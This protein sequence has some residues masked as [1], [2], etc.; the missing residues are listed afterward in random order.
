M[1]NMLNSVKTFYKSNPWKG[2]FILLFITI[3]LI[4]SVI[5]ISLPQTIIY[6]AT[7]WLNKQGIDS[8]IEA[9]NI[10]ILDGTVS[11]INAKGSK[12]NQPLFNIGLVDIH[13]RWAPLSKKTVE[14]TK[15]V[16]DQLNVNIEQYTDGIVIGG[17]YIPLNPS[18]NDSNTKSDEITNSDSE[19][20]TTWAASL[21]EVIFT[22]LNV[23]YLQHTSS[24]S[25]T[26]DKTKYIDYCALLDEMN[27]SGTINYATDAALIESSNLPLSSS[28]DFL[29]RGLTIIDNKLKRNL[30]TSSSNTISNVVFTGLNNININEINMSGLSA[31]Q[32]DDKQ[33]NDTV[34]FQQ[35]TISDISLTNLNSLD[36][37]TVAVSQP[38]LYLIK[39]D[40]KNWEYQP[41]LPDSSNDNSVAKGSKDKQSKTDPTPIKLTIKNIKIDDTDF[42]Y[43]ENSI[44]LYYCFTL[45][46]FTWDGS[47]KYVNAFSSTEDFNL[48]ARGALSLTHPVIINH[49]L[50]RTLLDLKSLVTN[51]INV[52]D[53]GEISIQQL[54]LNNLAAL[55]RSKNQSDYT[56][57]FSNLTITDTHFSKNN[58]AINSINLEGLSNSISKDSN[59]EW[60][61]NK[62]LVKNDIKPEANQS[63]SKKESDD[64]V[65]LIISLNKLDVTSNEK[66]LFTDNSTQPAMEIGLQ[67]L[68][69][70]INSLYTI[71]PDSDSPFN[72]H[73][74]TTDLS[75]FDVEG[76]ARPFAEKISFDAK[77]QL[78]GFDLRVVT[79]AIKKAIGHIIKSG[80][81]DADLQ[82]RATEGELDSKIAL[83]LYHFNIKPTSKADAEKLD[84]KFGMPLNQTL[85]LLRDKDDS[86]NLD[87]PITGDI[88][89]PDFN[90]MDAIVKATSKAATTTLI[91]FYTP[92]GLIYT[93]GNVLFDLATALNF[94]PIVFKAGSSELLSE[95]KEQL[96]KLSKLMTEKPKIHLTLCG[97]TNQG[98]LYAIN[99]KTKIQQGDKK[100]IT[101]SIEQVTA[102]N[103]LASQRQTNIKKYLI[104]E[105]NVTQDRLIL[106][107]PEHQED[108]NAIAGVEINI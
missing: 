58:I 107:A 83:S 42:C 79:P 1:N 70:N 82:L 5:R 78:K 60:E 25:D 13:W 80:Q 105:G 100:E 41:W 63:E 67:E 51:D 18:A 16:L 17:V 68:I 21:G 26:N 52:Q 31:L 61:H 73:A 65:P 11:L 99:P 23:C 85:V 22:N 43:L 27:W 46:Q 102:L 10:N 84:K 45:D 101:L 97:T 98:D 53:N 44:S 49:T 81:L 37:D 9:I 2:R 47:I 3:T 72:L 108:A 94:D 75:T 39:K 103:Q 106:C 40:H 66:I 48:T 69:F 55:Q 87:I 38:G 12:N 92:Y 34:R 59:G 62:W 14:V 20:S 74:K 8:S 50:Q 96:N 91:T 24:R 64:K 76:S 57:T 95:N 29:L 28:G 88:N 15:V 4:L 7:S 33:R 54:A 86:I 71:K 32:R 89:N 19:D 77:G 6:S 93:G 104:K 90:P 56:A 30:L 35:L 36:I